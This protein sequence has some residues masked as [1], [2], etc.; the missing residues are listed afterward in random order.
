ML[1]V[2]RSKDKAGVYCIYNAKIKIRNDY[3]CLTIKEN[4]GEMR[5]NLTKITPFISLLSESFSKN[6]IISQNIA[7]DENMIAF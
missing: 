1:L 2:K 3:C 4:V 6:N 5:N 7:I